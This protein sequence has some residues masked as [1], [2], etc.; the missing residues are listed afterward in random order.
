[1][2][3]L[4]YDAEG[5]W[6]GA[7][8][9][10]A[11]AA[12]GLAR[13]GHQVTFVCPAES[14]LERHL[15]FGSFET[16]AL[17][18]LTRIGAALRLRGELRERLIDVIFV[19]RARDH[20]VA[21]LAARLAERAAVLRR[22]GHG[23]PLR[24]ADF[25]TLRL[26]ASGF[27]FAMEDELKRARPPAAARIAHTLVPLGVDVAEY[28]EVRPAPPLVLGGPEHGA[29]HLVVVY[30]SVG[31]HAVGNALRVMAHVA[32]RHPELRLTA[33]GTGSQ[34]DDLRL[35]AAALRIPQRVSFLGT[36]DDELE[37][38]RA[39]ELG[40]VVAE[41]DTG[42]W[43]MLDLAALGVPVLAERSPLARHYI[44]D[45][46][47]GV[48]LPPSNPA[49]AAGIIARLLAGA[50]ERQ[51]MGAAA[52]ARVARAFPEAAMITAFENAALLAGDRSRW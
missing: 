10:L 40:W 50:D 51:A 23:E 45:G 5:T 41:G 18:P 17:P 52:R 21:A 14:R 38:L 35:H 29:R 27:L 15:A 37:I 36:R 39:A 8:R 4:F 3:I 49:D 7:A 44:A 46:I 19:R 12:H 13:R 43:G 28:A 16:R 1:M 31:R 33:V 48:H 11:R 42:A 9:A 6:T 25:L 2:R 47:T 26:T 32:Q 20:R 22:I 24:G 30:D 34:A